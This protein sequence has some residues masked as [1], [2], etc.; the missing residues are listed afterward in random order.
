M[1]S[2]TD[3]TIQK[4]EEILKSLKINVEIIRND[5]YF[6]KIKSIA[7][8]DK[9]ITNISGAGAGYS[10]ENAYAC[11]LGELLERLQNGMLLYQIDVCPK[12]NYLRNRFIYHGNTDGMRTYKLCYEH[13]EIS[14]YRFVE[15][16]TQEEILVS[17]D[18]LKKCCGS[19]GMSAGTTNEDSIIHGI[20]EIAEKYLVKFLFS[21]NPAQLSR[22]RLDWNSV[23]IDEFHG[24]L[25]ILRKDGYHFHV[26]DY[27]MQGKVPAVF[28]VLL[29]TK[30]GKFRSTVGIGISTAHAIEKSLLEMLCGATSDKLFWPFQHMND[31]AISTNL[32]GKKRAYKYQEWLMKSFSAGAIPVHS[33]KSFFMLNQTCDFI[34]PIDLK[35]LTTQVRSIGWEIFIRN[36]DMLGF[37]S[38]QVFIPDKS[39]MNAPEDFRNHDLA[40]LCSLLYCKTHS[41]QSLY[42]ILKII[43]KCSTGVMRDT[44][45]ISFLFPEMSY[46]PNEQHLFFWQAVE[47]I[48]LQILDKIQ[49][50]VDDTHSSYLT[51]I[52]L[53]DLAVA[54]ADGENPI[55][56][57]LTNDMEFDIDWVQ[58]LGLPMRGDCRKCSIINSCKQ[59][60][61]GQVLK[62]FE[63]VACMS[64]VEI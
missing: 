3:L 12:N 1:D 10:I 20:L 26:F 36:T 4:V 27:S 38:H 44:R 25:D 31:F 55:I 63:T 32:M 13:S 62:E 35:E 9:I 17:E 40:K 16:V 64:D 18:Y 59:F 22:G 8:R 57:W 15:A 61:I 2:R 34:G 41:L 28:A 29:D 24:V 46:S 19:S 56:D 30:T 53:L 33:L 60:A 7:I 6:G 5:N 48:Q 37:P 42:E 23:I 39:E 49:E 47:K 45:F 54:V 50:P 21:E 52:R 11:A 58:I 14:Y 43:G 51:V